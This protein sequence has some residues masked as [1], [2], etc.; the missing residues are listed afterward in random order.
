VKRL[1]TKPGLPELWIGLLRSRV[2]LIIDSVML[3]PTLLILLCSCAAMAQVTSGWPT[4]PANGKYGFGGSRW[5][6]KEAEVYTNSR[7]NAPPAILLAD[8]ALLAA[9]PFE[10]ET[11]AWRRS[12]EAALT[13]DGGW[14]TV[15]GRF[16]LHEGDNRFGRAAVSDIV[17]PDGPSHAGT[18][19]LYDNKVTVKMEGVTRVVRPNSGD[20]VRVGRLGLFVFGSGGSYS[21]RMKDPESRIRREFHG[22]EYYPVREEYRITARFFPAPRRI[23]D[24][25]CPGYLVFRLLGRELRLYP[26]EEQPDAKVLLLVFRDLTTG[27]E[28]YDGGR[29]LDIE[30]PHDDSVVLDFNRAYNPPCAFT[31]FVSCP[32][33]P[34]QNRLPLRIEAGEKKYSH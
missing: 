10:A 8:A 28:T 9:T 26:F 27:K 25:V 24:S 13:G 33:P 18:F 12:R 4:D 30:L 6:N 5:G 32:L 7:H 17:L 20:E 3:R 2:C 21:V 29:F 1:A 11:A 14:L 23:A 16:W 31:P 15:A 34:R 19:T 22:L